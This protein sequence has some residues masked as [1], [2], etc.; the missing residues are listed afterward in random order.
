ML[1]VFPLRL[2]IRQGCATTTSIH[3]YTEG[4]SSTIRKVK[5]ENEGLERKKQNDH[6]LWII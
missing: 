5:E 3:H 4:T 2:E 1:T 6:S